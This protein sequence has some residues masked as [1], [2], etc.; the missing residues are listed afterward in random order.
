MK[1]NFE[2]IIYRPIDEVYEFL[3][4]LD[5]RDFS[6]NPTVPVYE[7]ITEG[8]RGEGSIIREVVI[9][10]FLRMEIFSEIVRAISNEHLKYKFWSDGMRGELV[11]LFETVEEGTRLIQSVNIRFTGVQRIATPLLPLFYKP[12]VQKRLEAI[13]GLLENNYH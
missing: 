5:D 13:K 3:W 9:T 6:D 12:R 8:P 2:V 11:Y 4:T 1:F 10:P 7:R